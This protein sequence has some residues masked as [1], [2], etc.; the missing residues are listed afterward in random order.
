[1]EATGIICEYNPLHFGHYKQFRAIRAAYPDG[2][3][4][5]LMSGNYVQRGAPAV[6]DKSLRD[7]GLFETLEQMGIEDGDTVSIYDIEFEYQR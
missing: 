3:I 6:F 1:M 5:C 4:V 2:G 7:S